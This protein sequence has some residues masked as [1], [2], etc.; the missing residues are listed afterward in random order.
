[1][2]QHLTRMR[3]DKVS[4]V[5]AGANARTFA[6]LKRAGDV[7]KVMK[8]EDGKDFPASDYAYVPDPEAPSTWK[9]RL[10]S[11]P[12]GDPDPRIVGAAV[13][14][15]GAGFRGQRVDIPEGDRAGVIAKVR[16]AWKKAHPDAE[17]DEMP[18]VI[19]KADALDALRDA[20]WRVVVAKDGRGR[21]L[22]LVQKRAAFVEA[23]EAFESEGVAKAGKAISTAR[24]SDLKTAHRILGDLIAGATPKEA[25]AEA[26]ADDEKKDGDVQKQE[27]SVN[28]KELVEA[29]KPLIEE[30][31]NKAVSEALA[32]RDPDEGPTPGS[33]D[34]ITMGHVVAALAKAVDRIEALEASRSQAIAAQDATVAV[35]KRSKWEGLL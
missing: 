4:L 7:A 1:M 31:V 19:A 26:E 6:I 14:A 12:G 24:M 33:E 5:D 29:M 9:L 23:F 13:A 17:E 34:D 28:P 21:P 2:P 16:S 3:I 10:T 11:S 35:A 30:A 32:K 18:D 20:M 8:T 25:E 15:L 27:A 22:T